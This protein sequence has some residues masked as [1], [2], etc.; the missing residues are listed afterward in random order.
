VL[1]AV[2]VGQA[3]AGLRH[4]SPAARYDLA[5]VSTAREEVGDGWVLDGVKAW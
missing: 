2:I 1:P 3:E 5:Q 4:R